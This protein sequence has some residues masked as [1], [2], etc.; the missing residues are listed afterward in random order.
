MPVIRRSWERRP[1]LARSTLKALVGAKFAK[2][3]PLSSFTPKRSGARPIAFTA[4]YRLCEGD[5]LSAG[6][7]SATAL[8]AEALLQCVVS[9]D[10]GAR[11]AHAT[12]FAIR[13]PQYLA[14]T[15]TLP[16]ASRPLGDVSSTGR[17][18]AK[19]YVDGTRFPRG[20]RSRG[21]R[22]SPDDAESFDS[23]RVRGV[24]EINLST[25]SAGLPL[26]G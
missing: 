13:K 24:H 10:I 23:W 5:V 15:T 25:D 12:C 20:R 22:A 26:N 9:P 4:L 17:A 18:A 14:A 7:L 8:L 6:T 11:P 16:S 19:Q 21:T 3:A 2:F 1:G